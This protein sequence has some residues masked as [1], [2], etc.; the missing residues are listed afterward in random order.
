MVVTVPP[1]RSGSLISDRDMFSS[2]SSVGGFSDESGSGSVKSKRKLFAAKLSAIET[3]EVRLRIMR[4]LDQ[5]TAQV[6]EIEEQCRAVITNEAMGYAYLPSSFSAYVAS[7]THEVDDLAS[8]HRSDLLTPRTASV[9]S[10]RIPDFEGRKKSG[11]KKA[12]DDDGCC[13]I[14]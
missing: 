10:P 6:V 3:D 2:D 13:V 5:Q 7:L 14:C 9:A 11:K 8:T 4:V 1:P 12:K